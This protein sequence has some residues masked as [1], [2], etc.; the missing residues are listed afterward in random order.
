MQRCATLQIPR[1]QFFPS[2]KNPRSTDKKL[3]KLNFLW[4][5]ALYRLMR[6]FT[7][8]RYKTGSFVTV[9]I[10]LFASV[11]CSRKWQDTY[12]HKN[13]FISKKYVVSI[14]AHKSFHHGIDYVNAANRYP[15]KNRRDSNRYLAKTYKTQTYIPQ[16]PIKHKNRRDFTRSVA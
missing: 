10:Y 8:R 12:T 2:R 9:G 4:V 11:K 7:A 13:M 3:K 16:K 15:S 6:Q 5:F 14:N 1:V